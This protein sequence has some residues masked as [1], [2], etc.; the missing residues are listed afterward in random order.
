LGRPGASLENLHF[1]VR[2]AQLRSN[3]ADKIEKI[4]EWLRDHP[5]VAVELAGYLDQVE[6]PVASGA[7]QEQR[8]VVVR[9][10]LVKAGVAPAR[11]RTVATGD[12]VL[13]C[14]KNTDESC[15]QWN[16]RVEVMIAEP[17][18]N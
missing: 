18:R 9:N 17:S 8:A 15:R 13:K 14:A 11:I 7:L 12:N 2:T 5:T 10:E 16:R 6:A 1:E 4:A 3:C